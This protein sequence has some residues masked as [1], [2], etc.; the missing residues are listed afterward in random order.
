MVTCAP[1]FPTGKVFNGYSNKLFTREWIEGIRVIRVW[2][3]ISANKGFVKRIMD[4]ISFSITALLFSIQI[5]CDI[6]IATSPQ[7]FT[8]IAGMFLS[9]IKSKPW[10]MEI[11][12]LWPESIIAVGALKNKKIIQFLQWLEY[13]CYH[14]ADLL[15]SVTDS[16]K[17]II[18]KK[19]ISA[20]KIFVV[21]N[22]ANLELYIP[23][24]KDSSFIKNNKLEGKFVVGYIGTLGMAHGLDFIIESAKELLDQSIHIILMG[25]GAKKGDLQKLIAQDKISNV[26]ILNS[27]HKEKVNSVISS[28]DV[29]LINLKKSELFK[30]VIP[31]KIFENAAMK[32]PILLG[33]EGESK[34]IIVQYNAGL[35]YEPENT[36][37]FIKKLMLLKNNKNL[38]SKCKIGCQNL[39]VDYD[40]KNLGND[41]LQI[42]YD[43][44]GF[45]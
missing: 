15:I 28:I 30:T 9:K 18:I 17:K 3:Y 34:E 23:Q 6:I 7:F 35:C 26:S 37:D 19:G 31:S 24:D 43:K 22:G 36:T 38:Y 5:K 10:I 32:K 33:V 21:K 40:R 29:S 27:V 14:S 13:K 25:D 8:A 4:Y 20:S 1:N 41:M 42:I 11:R 16:F 45:A 2:S 44:F 12:D 39:A